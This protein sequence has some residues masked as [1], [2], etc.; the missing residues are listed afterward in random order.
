MSDPVPQPID[1][2]DAASVL[3]A[4]HPVCSHDLP[5]QMV[6]LHSLLHLV[7]MEEVDRLSDD[8]RE[9][10]HRLHR[11]AEKTATLV[12]FLKEAVRLVSY[13]PKRGRVDLRELLEEVRHESRKFFEVV[14]A[15]TVEL[16]IPAVVCDEALLLQAF[17][18]LLK[19]LAGTST[20]TAVR[21]ESRV[22]GDA[23]IVQMAMRFA[24]PAPSAWRD[25]RLEVVLARARLQ[26]MRILVS[27]LTLASPEL[28]GVRLRF[29]QE[30]P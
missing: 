14:P 26:R 1:V 12:D 27:P 13:Q 28:V 17:A 21:W 23:A 19:G 16:G 11:V 5:N 2:R 20:V 3:A 25:P 6:S 15:W 4:V 7:E 30:A 22:D 8:G 9:Y 10:L 24:S 29:P 18:D